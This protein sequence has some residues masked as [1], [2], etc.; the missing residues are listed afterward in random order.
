MYSKNYPQNATPFHVSSAGGR[1]MP[2]CWHS[3]AS[4][5]L[6]L[7]YLLPGMPLLQRTAPGL[8]SVLP[9]GNDPLVTR[10]THL[11]SHCLAMTLASGFAG[12]QVWV[13]TPDRR[14]WPHFTSIQAFA[15]FAHQTATG[16]RPEEGRVRD[17]IHICENGDSQRL[18]GFQ[19]PGLG[20]EDGEPNEVW[21]LPSAWLVGL[22]SREEA[23]GDLV[24]GRE[25]KQQQGLVPC[26]HHRLCG[27]GPSLGLLGRDPCPS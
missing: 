10:V 4:G 5:P 1:A 20:L 12:S 22:G 27:Y 16:L 14:P 17:P 15:S 19:G 8:Q 18:L 25:G 21:G 3:H 11:L 24:V 6:L 26:H 9:Q 2:L 23:A 7:R 13:E